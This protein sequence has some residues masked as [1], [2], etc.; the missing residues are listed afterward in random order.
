[1][2]LDKNWV[3]K[4]QWGLRLGPINRDFIPRA[5]G[6]FEG[7]EAGLRGVGLHLRLLIIRWGQIGK[8]CTEDREE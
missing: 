7:I 2:F 5:I 6:S 1:M 8:S 3:G 4:A